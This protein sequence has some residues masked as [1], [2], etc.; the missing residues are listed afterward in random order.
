VKTAIKLYRPFSPS[1]L[2]EKAWQV[3]TG[4]WKWTAH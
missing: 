4:N 2:W 3:Q 1:S